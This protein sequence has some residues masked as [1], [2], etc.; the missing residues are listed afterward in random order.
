MSSQ[1]SETEDFGASHCS[2]S[3]CCLDAKDLPEEQSM[4][5][6]IRKSHRLIKMLQEQIYLLQNQIRRLASDR[7]CRES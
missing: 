6:Q 7:P 4:N 2:T 3:L 1:K 5:G